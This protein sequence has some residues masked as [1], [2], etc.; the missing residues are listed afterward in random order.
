MI[1]L[2]DHSLIEDEPKHI[3]ADV[4]FSIRRLQKHKRTQICV[5]IYVDDNTGINVTVKDT[6]PCN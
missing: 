6:S 1:H 2:P 3:T 5:N 4:K